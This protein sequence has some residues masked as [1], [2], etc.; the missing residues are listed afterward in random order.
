MTLPSSRSDSSDNSV[1]SDSSY[2]SDSSDMSDGSN[3]IDS[4]DQIL[5]LSFCSI[6]TVVTTFVGK[7][8]NRHVWSYKASTTQLVT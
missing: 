8:L 2:S 4:S 6:S 5:V 1:S 7:T 3:T